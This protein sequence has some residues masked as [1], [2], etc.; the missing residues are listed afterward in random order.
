MN[1]KR[2]PGTESSTDDEAPAAASDVV[3]YGVLRGLENHTFVPGQ[4]LVEAD[5]ALAF[6]V[7]RN[8]VREGLQRLVSEGVIELLKHRGAVI[9]TLDLRDTMAVLDVAEL[10]TGLLLRSAAAH[11][12][13]YPDLK[14]TLMQ[15][16]DDL[17]A[18]HDSRDDPT[19]NRSRRVLYRALLD[20]ANNGEL[21]RLFPMIGMP[22]V[23]AQ[24]RLPMLQ[25]IRVRDYRRMVAV[26]SSG[27]TEAAEE[28][29][30][31][32]VQNV[33]TCICD[34]YAKRS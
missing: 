11:Q 15:S 27:E 14:R 13:E 5:L 6:G 20:M 10:M 30:R 18:A 24:H 31:Q 12:Q 3:F 22:I 1:T 8:S 19:F 17:Q 26:V 16:L 29:G 21:R 33:R 32:H 9:R 25:Q 2:Q 23:Y 28:L 7:S 34:N 4:R